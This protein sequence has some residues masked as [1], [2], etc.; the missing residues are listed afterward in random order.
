MKTAFII[1][2]TNAIKI[3]KSWCSPSVICEIQWAPS[4]FPKTHHPQPEPHGCRTQQLYPMPHTCGKPSWPHLPPGPPHPWQSLGLSP[5]RRILFPPLVSHCFCNPTSA[6]C[7]ND[8]HKL[9]VFNF[10]NSISHFFMSCVEFLCFVPH[11]CTR[12]ARV[13]EPL[14]W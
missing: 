9:T 4:Q 14:R 3:H 7:T 1:L 13:K 2:S 8:A 5:E 6:A 12:R 10:L 11:I